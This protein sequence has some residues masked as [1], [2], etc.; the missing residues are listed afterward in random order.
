M[1]IGIC[2][3]EKEICL[4]IKKLI[5][6]TAPDSQVVCYSSGKQ[7][8]A[9]RQHF[10][11]LFLDIQMGDTN[12]MEI[13]RTLRERRED[14]ILIFVTALKE[15]VFEAFDV[16]AFHYLLKPLANDKFSNVF[17]EALKEAGKRIR[18]REESLF[19]FRRN[20]GVLH[21]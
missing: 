10:D 19:F 2:D 12:G 13:A 16:S 17:Q 6:A 9:E 14:T 7:F 20:H 8:L 21:S 18:G 3:D 4:Q 11:I 15:Y 5:L 1:N